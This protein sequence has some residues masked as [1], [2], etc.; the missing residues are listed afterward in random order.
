[1]FAAVLVKQGV[2]SPEQEGRVCLT[3]QGGVWEGP[4]ADWGDFADQ[5]DPTDGTLTGG[6]VRTGLVLKPT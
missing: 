1:M 5:G 6:A 4:L 2:G 3:I